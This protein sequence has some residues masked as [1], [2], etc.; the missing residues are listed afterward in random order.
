MDFGKK[1]TTKTSAARLALKKAFGDYVQA[2]RELHEAMTGD[3]EYL[4]LD[5][6]DEFND[7]MESVQMFQH[8]LLRAME[9]LIAEEKQERDRNHY[10]AIVRAIPFADS[11]TLDATAKQFDY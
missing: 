9:R 6:A 4:H 7:A 8:L 1:K 5:G 3:V 10:L 2:K 11:A